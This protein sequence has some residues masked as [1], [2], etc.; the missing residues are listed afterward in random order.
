LI[1]PGLATPVVLGIVVGAFA[2]TRVLV[3]L[4]NQAVRQFFLVVL[5]VLGVEMIVRGIL[6]GV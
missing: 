6:G 2:G 3:R 1:D 5:L 4:T